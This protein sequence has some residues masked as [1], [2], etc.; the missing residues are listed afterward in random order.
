MELPHAESF[1]GVYL[2]DS[3]EFEGSKPNTM[4]G[5]PML[6]GE[7]TSQVGLVV[8]VLRDSLAGV[9]RGRRQMD[10]G[11]TLEELTE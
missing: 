3:R 9:R 6:G 8:Y 5:V 10:T 2:R 4:F 1:S 11:Q 7:G